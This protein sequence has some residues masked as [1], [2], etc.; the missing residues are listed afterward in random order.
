VTRICDPLY[1][2]VDKLESSRTAFYIRD[3]TLIMYFLSDNEEREDDADD[4][5]EPLPED[6]L[7]SVA[8]FERDADMIL[9][10]D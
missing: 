8:Q 2:E 4:S 7:A 1:A 3:I 6:I 5:Q 10:S 9:N